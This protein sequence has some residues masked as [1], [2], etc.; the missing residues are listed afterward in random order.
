MAPPALSASDRTTT[1]KGAF[2]LVSLLPRASCASTT[3]EA[4]SPATALCVPAPWI[5]HAAKQMS[6]GNTFTAIGHLGNS[7]PSSVTLTECSPTSG[8]HT[9]AIAVVA[10]DSSSRG[11]DMDIADGEMTRTENASAPDITLPNSGFLTSTTTSVYPPHRNGPT[12]DLTCK[13]L[14]TSG[15]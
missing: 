9:V 13:S 7:A 8:Q 3:N 1:P 11:T 15:P 5:W 4:R 10:P 12:G 2:P 14:A 6:S